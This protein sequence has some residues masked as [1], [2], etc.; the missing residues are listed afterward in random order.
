MHLVGSKPKPG[1][2][3]G[4]S[5]S[6]GLCSI[7]RLAFQELSSSVIIALIVPLLGTL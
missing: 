1:N 3:P 7:H 5:S 6:G 2:V 4:S